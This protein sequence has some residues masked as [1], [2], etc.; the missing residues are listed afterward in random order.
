MKPTLR[1]LHCYLIATLLRPLHCHLIAPLLRPLHCYLIAITL[2]LLTSCEK[3]V[4]TDDTAPPTVTLTFAPV[5]R[6]F[7]RT[8][9]ITAFT[10]LNVQLFNADGE[11]VFDKVKTQT[12]DGA[13]FGTMSLKLSEGT[14]TIVAV[15]H[16]STISAT[17]KSPTVCQ[18]TASDGEKLT[19]TFCHCS[20][21]SI[22]SS[23]TATA[24]Y[25]LPM[26]R[27][28]AMI[29]FVLTDTQVPDNFTHFLMEYTGGSANFNPTTLEGITK[30]TQSERRLRNTQNVHQAYTFP[31]LST[32]C[33]LKMTVSGLDADGTVIRKRTFDNVPVTRN[34][35]TTYTGHFFE[36][37]DGTFTQ[38]DFGFVVHTDW[39]G[40]DTIIF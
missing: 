2:L 36:D 13:D 31:Y 9:S 29:Q 37:G 32:S 17:I 24:Q 7:T 8:Q 34:R 3:P 11:K 18:F 40:E 22:P 12:N 23:S 5:F 38:S 33:T 1:P 19:D 30:S 26:Y 27:V 15:G 14:Y 6:D 35:I 28:A 16:S 21:I 4:P 10:K 39:D 25:T 20:T